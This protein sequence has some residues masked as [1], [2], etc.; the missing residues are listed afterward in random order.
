[1]TFFQPETCIPATHRNSPCGTSEFSA[2]ERM[3]QQTP[4]M[5]T[6]HTHL[7][8]SLAPSGPPH[9]LR[10][11]RGIRAL[12][13]CLLTSS[14]FYC[15]HSSFHYLSLDRPSSPHTWKAAPRHFLHYISTT[16]SDPITGRNKDFLPFP[17]AYKI[18]LS[19]NSLVWHMIRFRL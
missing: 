15:L 13:S 19:P 10:C 8:S 5:G 7:F 14:Q 4:S 16:I 6:A 3:T 12:L 9:P 18:Y 2:Q 11:P 1:M 17:A